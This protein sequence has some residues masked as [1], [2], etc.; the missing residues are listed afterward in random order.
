MRIFIEVTTP[1]NGRTYELM[2]DDKLTVGAAKERI[3]EEIR[4][5]ENGSIEFNTGFSMFSPTSRT[6]LP[7]NR[8][9]RKAGVRSGQQIFLL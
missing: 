9:L 4:A 2:L 3:A 6:R 8:N 1:G 7:D 5:F